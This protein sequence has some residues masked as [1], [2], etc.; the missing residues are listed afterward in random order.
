MMQQHHYPGA[1]GSV[2][3]QEHAVDPERDPHLFAKVFSILFGPLTLMVILTISLCINGWTFANAMYF[4]MVSMTTIGYGD[5]DLLPNTTAF[6]LLIAG[7]LL[8]GTSALA[9]AIS[10]A[11]TIRAQLR[12]RKTNWKMKSLPLLLDRCKSNP[13]RE[14][15]QS[16]FLGAVLI[17]MDV[18]THETLAVINAKFHDVAGIQEVVDEDVSTSLKKGGPLD[19][20]H[21]HE[22][23][24]SAK[25]LY[26]HLVEHRQVLDCDDVRGY[27]RDG[28]E[29]KP[30]VDLCAMDRG[31]KEW[32][33]KY[34]RPQVRLRARATNGGLDNKFTTIRRNSGNS[35]T[36]PTPAAVNHAVA[37][38]VSKSPM[39]RYIQGA[40]RRSAGTGAANVGAVTSVR[41]ATSGRPPKLPQLFSTG[42]GGPAE[43]GQ[44]CGKHAFERRANNPSP[45]KP[46]PTNDKP[47]SSDPSHNRGGTRQQPCRGM[48]AGSSSGRGRP[49]GGQQPFG[50]ISTVS[51]IWKGDEI[52]NLKV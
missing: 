42:I 37:A 49:N 19:D 34:W 47:I 1:K 22:K 30:H 7:F 52:G 36:L 33:D 3:H 5:S 39:S 15:T 46:Q 44:T 8:V 48:R 16:D 25:V 50:L 18:I 27:S 40:I 43:D 4:S 38:E 45:P 11:T 10:E 41:G 14:L 28:K 31:Y 13:H 24:I 51:S 26:A 32:F 23:T 35:A 2:D 6:K 9:T 29:I 20:I 12:I 21:G 17:D